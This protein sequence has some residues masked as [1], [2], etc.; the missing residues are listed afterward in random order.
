VGRTQGIIPD[1]PQPPVFDLGK[2]RTAGT[3]VFVA[4]NRQ[5]ERVIHD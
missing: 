2:Q 3:T 5:V 1:S 4:G